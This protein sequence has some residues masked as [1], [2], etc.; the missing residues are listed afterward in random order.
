MNAG[1]VN[2]EQPPAARGPSVWHGV[3]LGDQSQWTYVLAPQQVS[4]LTAAV[5]KAQARGPDI[6]TIDAKNFPLPSWKD[7]ITEVREELKDGR[8]F[9]LMRGV[10]V[11]AYTYEESQIAFWGIGAHFGTGLT[12]SARADLIC[13]ITNRNESLAKLERTYATTLGLDFHCDFPDIVGLLC[14][15]TAMKGGG[16]HVVSSGAIYNT[17]RERRPDLLPYLL[18]GFPWDRRNEHGEGEAA[19]GPRTPVFR[20]IDG[21]IHCRYA[22]GSTLAAAERSGVPLRPDEREAVDLVNATAAD[23]A[24]VLTMDFK[25]GDIQLLNNYKVL[26]ARAAY[27]DYPEP[28]R[29][30]HL[31]RLWLESEAY[32]YID[33]EPDIRHGVLRYGKL[34]LSAG[35]LRNEAQTQALKGDRS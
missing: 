20:E 12:Q 2:T 15:K 30:R 1:S 24:L 29:K 27:E 10:P 25:P 4:E 19:I 13:D 28:E 3:E 7:L 9:V 14:L 16:S 26:H 5:K 6:G 11:E 33:G 18:K 23:P 32:G 21:T 22:R 31:L 8:G 35:D 34:G 17:I